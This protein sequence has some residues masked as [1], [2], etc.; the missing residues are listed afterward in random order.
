MSF[1]FLCL[2]QIC[3]IFFLGKKF[4]KAQAEFLI[5]SAETACWDLANNWFGK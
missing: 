5:V 3:K 4:P 1:E 2:G